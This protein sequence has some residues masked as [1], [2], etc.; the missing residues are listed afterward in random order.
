M[1]R[2][3]S[4]LF[5][6]GHQHRLRLGHF[7]R[8]AFLLP[9]GSEGVHRPRVL[10]AARNRVRR[11]GRFRQGVCHRARSRP[12][13]AELVRHRRQGAARRSSSALRRPTRTR[14]P[15][16]MELQADC[17]AGIW[18]HYADSARQVV[19]AGDIDEA[20]N[21][22]SAVG[23]DTIQKRVQGHVNQESF[24]HGSGAAAPAVVPQGLRVR[25]R[26]GLQHF[27]VSAG[28]RARKPVATGGCQCGAVRYAFY[29]PLENA[30]VCHCRMCQRATGGVF[31]ALA[32]AVAGQLLLDPR[33]AG[34]LRELQSRA[35]RLLRANAARRCRSSTTRQPRACTPPSARSIIPKSARS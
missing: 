15:V 12:P 33:H 7:G 19:E 24:T 17:Y 34:I 11:A 6:A 35:T 25:P 16:R 4:R 10:P 31:A 13:R 30:H 2:R 5:S 20:L 1:P 3:T 28:R 18:A 27:P 21:A 23:D 32:G 26:A 22:A 14:C 8:R 29:A 9:A